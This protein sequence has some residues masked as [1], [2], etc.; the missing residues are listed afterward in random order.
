MASSEDPAIQAY[1]PNPKGLLVTLARL[2]VAPDQAIYAGDRPEVD[3]EAVGRVGVRAVIVSR[4]HGY[5]EFR[6]LLEES[7]LRRK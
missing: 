2:G 1:K 3:A 6:R 7:L 5:P 4:A